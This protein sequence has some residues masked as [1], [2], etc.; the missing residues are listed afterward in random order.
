[1]EDNSQQQNNTQSGNIAERVMMVVD[2][3]IQRV[4]QII[5]HFEGLV[6]E[7]MDIFYLL[8]DFW[9]EVQGMFRP[10][11]HRRHESQ[12]EVAGI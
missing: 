12:A 11:Q 9:K 7:L 8:R 10:Q 4:R 1:M 6:H 3:V 2:E 5:D